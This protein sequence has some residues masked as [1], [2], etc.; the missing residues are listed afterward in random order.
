[1]KRL[2]LLATII[3]FTLNSSHAQQNLWKSIID[4]ESI[5]A[6]K[7]PRDSHPAKFKLFSM[8][9]D[10]LRANLE[11]AP[12]RGADVQSNLIVSFPNSH[13]ELQR[14]RIF[15][16][17]VMHPELAVRHP[18]MK[19]YVG[20]GIDDNSTI[21]FSVTMFGLH[22]AI[23]S[24]KDGT[25]YL[26]TFTKDL[27]NYIVYNK[28]ISPPTK[29]LHVGLLTM[30]LTCRKSYPDF[31]RCTVPITACLK[32]IVLPWH[33]PLSTPLFMSMPPE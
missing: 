4:Q 2:L 30:V 9:L 23:F 25:S 27:M 1:M 11:N 21:R 13:G 15:E 3:F 14:Y 20:K 29:L 31:Q 10:E 19:S 22:A 8:N 6:E 26:D 33:V 32:P 5:S 24:A 28:A 12:L 16:A 7:L 18:D 17:P